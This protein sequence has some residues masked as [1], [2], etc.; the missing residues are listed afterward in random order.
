MYFTNDKNKI[1][2]QCFQWS[3]VG[4]AS[5]QLF[6]RFVVKKAADK[7][8]GVNVDSSVKKKTTCDGIIPRILGYDICPAFVEF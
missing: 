2:R 4:S 3:R 7:I 1:N 6:V 8:V 5:M